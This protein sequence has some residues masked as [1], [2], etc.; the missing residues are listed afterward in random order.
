MKCRSVGKCVE[1]FRIF[2]A[3]RIAP[4]TSP[5]VYRGAKTGLGPRRPVATHSTRHK[6]KALVQVQAAPEMKR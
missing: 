6:Q 2:S 3:V 5:P 1:S 4:G